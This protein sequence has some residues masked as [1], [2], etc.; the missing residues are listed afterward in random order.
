[1]SR[2]WAPIVLGVLA[3]IGGIVAILNPFA[4]TIAATALAAWFFLILGVLMLVAA[5]RGEDERWGRVWTGLTGVFGVL[6]GIFILVRPFA[7][8][9]SLTLVVGVMFL[10]VGV[11]R[12]WLAWKFRGSRYFWL[13][14]IGGALSVLLGAIIVANFPA[15]ALTVLGIL[16]AVELLS[17]GVSMI[18]L[19]LMARDRN[20]DA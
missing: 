20:T 16:L 1:M 17:S 9:L 15:A 3:V 14:L 5:F 10:A 13:L 8:M 6:A 19:G 18:V 4:A 11:T 7:G 2:W 12:L